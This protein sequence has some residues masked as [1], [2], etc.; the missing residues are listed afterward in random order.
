[1]LKVPIRTDIHFP[2]SYCWISCYAFRGC[3]ILIILS[4]PRHTHLGNRD[5]IR[6]TALIRASLFDADYW[7]VYAHDSSVY[8]W[9]NSINAN[10]KFKLHR[11]CSSLYPDEDR[12][13]RIIKRYGSLRKFT[14]PKN[15]IGITP[16]EYLYEN[17]FADFDQTKLVKRFVLEMMGETV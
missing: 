4:V 10:R 16:L 11:I 14:K 6:S 15:S 9:I 13:Y 8:E 7:G 12:T 2:S 1:M 5:A 17:P 3:R